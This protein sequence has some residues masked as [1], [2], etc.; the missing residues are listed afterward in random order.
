MK[1]KNDCGWRDLVVGLSYGDH[2]NISLDTETKRKRADKSHF[3]SINDG[4]SY[5]IFHMSITE[6]RHMAEAI[7]K[8]TAK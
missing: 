1:F 6:L 7:L 4:S 8:E 3:I 2:I 5:A